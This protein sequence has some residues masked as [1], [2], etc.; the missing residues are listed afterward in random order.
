MPSCTAVCQNKSL[1]V[2]RHLGVRLFGDGTKPGLWTLD[3]GP[4]N[5]LD[6]GLKTARLAIDRETGAAASVHEPS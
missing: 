5:G 6:Y 2:T 3:Y 1:R 4:K